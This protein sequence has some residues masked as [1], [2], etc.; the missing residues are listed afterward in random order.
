MGGIGS[1]RWGLHVK[2][3]TVESCKRLTIRSLGKLDLGA[4]DIHLTYT[5]TPRLGDPVR[6]DYWV[7]LTWTPTPWGARRWWFICPLVTDGRACGKRAAVL[8]LPPGG[9]FFGCRSCYN[10]TYRSCQESHQ[11]ENLYK[12]MAQ[13]IG[14][15]PDD[16]RESFEALDYAKTGKL[17]PWLESRFKAKLTVMESERQAEN[18]RRLQELL[19]FDPYG[20]YLTPG[21]LCEQSGLTLDSLAALESARLLLP[22]HGGKYRPKLAG[23]GRKLAYLLGEGWTMAELAA[24]A[25]GRWSTPDPRRFPPERA[26][27]QG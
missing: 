12:Q 25:R 27:W 20:H 15:S 3:T 14:K 16:V 13:M 26:A 6:L 23:W 4:Q 21:E 2:K 11:R 5:I 7:S 24:W 10:L 18:A 17:S 9:R 22:D 19:D 8:Y 1:G